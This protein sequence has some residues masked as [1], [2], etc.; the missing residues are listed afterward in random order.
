MPPQKPDDI[1]KK[2]E[3]YLH[4]EF[5]KLNTK[6]T[7]KIEYLHGGIP[8]VADFKHW[9]YEA[10]KIATEVSSGTITRCSFLRVDIGGDPSAH[11]IA[12]SPWAAASRPCTM[13]ALCVNPTLTH[14]CPPRTYTSR[15][16]TSR[17]KVRHPDLRER[18]FS[19]IIFIAGGSIPV[20]LTFAE[21]LGVNVLLLPMGRGDDGAQCV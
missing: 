10:A 8:W 11:P 1:R 19:L 12:F 21:N 17:G 15:R 20:T 2:V 9:N 14:D 5:A 3:K 6:C 16:L 7:M 4:D 13:F 18:L